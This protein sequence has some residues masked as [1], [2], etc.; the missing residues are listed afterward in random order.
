M[1]EKLNKITAQTIKQVI[2]NS[3]DIPTMLGTEQILTTLWQ[4]SGLT[5][6]EIIKAAGK[7]E[8]QWKNAIRTN[9]IPSLFTCMRIILNSSTNTKLFLGRDTKQALFYI[10]INSLSENII[11]EI[12]QIINTYKAAL[13]SQYAAAI[14]KCGT[15]T[16]LC[17]SNN[18]AIQRNFDPHKNDINKIHKH[19]SALGIAIEIT[20]EYKNNEKSKSE[21]TNI[22]DDDKQTL[23]TNYNTQQYPFSE[24]QASIILR[25]T[26]QKLSTIMRKPSSDIFHTVKIHIEDFKQKEDKNYQISKKGIQRIAKE[27]KAS[28]STTQKKIKEMLENPVYTISETAKII[29]VPETQ[30]I[31]FIE[32]NIN[33]INKENKI[34]I[35]NFYDKISKHILRSDTD[36]L[37]KLFLQITN[38]EDNKAKQQ[39][40]TFKVKN[41]N[42]TPEGTVNMPNRKKEQFFLTAREYEDIMEFINLYRET[43]G[44]EGRPKDEPLFQNG[45]TSLEDAYDT[46]LAYSPTKEKADAEINIGNHYA[47]ISRKYYKLQYGEKFTYKNK[48]FAFEKN[49]ATNTTYLE[50]KDETLRENVTTYINNI[51]LGTEPLEVTKEKFKP[52]NGEKYKTYDMFRKEFIIITKGDDPMIDMFQEEKGLIFRPDDELTKEDIINIIKSQQKNN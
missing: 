40:E 52:A 18:M 28:P 51:L 6:E 17:I 48:K 20:K 29:G 22:S 36:K 31:D 13:G 50:S 21:R 49:Q 2:E 27:Y 9:N 1:L 23:K 4:I 44:D 15:P 32:N 45:K 41:K 24:Y 11:E 35:T 43:Y 38:L 3:Q 12:K 33:E 47:E 30:L 10:S 14:R 46:I 25:M 34:I 19:L 39:S 5:K 37:K 8:E 42:I 26:P 16:Q 7:T